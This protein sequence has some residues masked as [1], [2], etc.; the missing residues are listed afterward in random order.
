MKL[1]WTPAPRR[2]GFGE[3]YMAIGLLAIATARF[4]PFDRIQGLWTCPLYGMTGVPCPTCG[5]TRAF[6]RTAHLHFAHAFEVSPLGTMLFLF[7]VVYVVFALL[8]LAF[9]WPWP[10]V[11]VEGRFEGYL[12]RVGILVMVAGNWAYLLVRHFVIGDWG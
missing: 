9:G 10:R 3:I 7:I 6:V 2:F 5:F 1:A 8:R 12:F 11:V 4:F